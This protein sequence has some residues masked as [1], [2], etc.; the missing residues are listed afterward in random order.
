MTLVLNL[1]PAQMPTLYQMNSE[2]VKYVKPLYKNS[3]VA[4]CKIQKIVY[5]TKHENHNRREN[6]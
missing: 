4:L 3:N 5:N 1:I 6:P 2:C